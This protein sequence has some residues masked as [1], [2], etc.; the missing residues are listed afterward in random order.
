MLLAAV[1]QFSAERIYNSKVRI[2]ENKPA[3]GGGMSTEN[4]SHQ[5]KDLMRAKSLSR[6]LPSADP[7]SVSNCIRC[8]WSWSLLGNDLKGQFDGIHY[9]WVASES[10]ITWKQQ[11]A[12]LQLLDLSFATME[13]TNG[14]SGCYD[15]RCPG[16]V[17]VYDPANDPLPTMGSG[18]FEPP[19]F[20]KTGFISNIQVH[21][22]NENPPRE[23]DLEACADFP[24]CYRANSWETQ[25]THTTLPS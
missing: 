4:C 16:F 7:S 2:C 11:N 18:S 23:P 20:N 14:N 8:Y 17:Q 5:E 9:R 13:A 22:K 1:A 25:E 10:W 15:L 6:F 19:E 12:N 24:A 21:V 3:N